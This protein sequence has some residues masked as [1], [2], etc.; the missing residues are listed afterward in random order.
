MLASTGY[1]PAR[2]CKYGRD[3]PGIL[4]KSQR[5]G[6]PNQ[7]LPVSPKSQNFWLWDTKSMLSSIWKKKT[8]GNSQSDEIHFDDRHLILFQNSS[9][10]SWW[11]PNFVLSRPQTLLL[12][13]YPQSFKHCP[14][15]T[16]SAMKPRKVVINCGLIN[17]KTFAHLPCAS[18]KIY[19]THILVTSTNKYI[20]C[21]RTK[22]EVSIDNIHWRAKLCPSTF[23]I[24]FQLFQLGP[25]HGNESLVPQLVKYII[26][27][28]KSHFQT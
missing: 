25:D 19:I 28:S 24:L 1:D 16:N 26:I 20:H 21:F 2:G 12:P 10:L 9:G 5:T 11:Q 7:N 15:F 3:T 4:S 27:L 14:G 23:G 6:H 17:D 13:R 22:F 8:L 18:E